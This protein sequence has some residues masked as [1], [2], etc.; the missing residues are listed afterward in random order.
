MLLRR[1]G[2][3]LGL[4][5]PFVFAAPSCSGPGALD[6]GFLP[7]RADWELVFDG[8]FPYFDDEGLPQIASVSVGGSVFNDNFANRGDII[9]KMTG[10]DNKITVEMREFTFAASQAD[11][12]EDFAKL[13]PWVYGSNPSSP[14]Q[15]DDMNPEADCI[16]AGWQEGC[17]IRVWYDGQIQPGRLGADIRV[18]LPASYRN[19]VTIETEDN[20][21]EDAYQDRGN[22][23]VENANGNFEIEMGSGQ[24]Y[25]IASSDLTPGPTCSAAE[26]TGCEE[27]TDANDNPAAWAPECPC[28]AFGRFVV[29]GVAAGAAETIIDIPD[30]VWA[31]MNLDNKAPALEAANCTAEIP[32]AGVV[33]DEATADKPH[34]SR[35]EINHPSDAA[36]NGG[37]FNIRAESEGCAPVRYTENPADYPGPE[38]EDDQES[39]NRGNATVCSN[40]IRGQTCEQLMTWTQ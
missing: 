22:V 39:E 15:P 6:S 30:T 18:T 37:G 4:L 10:P 11:A 13:R 26:I 7:F 5:A 29:Q 20:T 2:L 9:V 35:G 8:E 23:C 16:S 17:G 32:I 31:S 24:A 27:Y 19:E 3:L 28:Q 40:C 36:V 21:L 14:K 25:I 33:I 1:P 34:Q 38:N 12:D